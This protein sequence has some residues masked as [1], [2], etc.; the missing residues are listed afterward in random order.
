MDT[1]RKLSK[2]ERAALKVKEALKREE[3]RAK[4]TNNEALML[5]EKGMLSTASVLEKFGYDPDEEIER[6]RYDV[7]QMEYLGRGL[8]LGREDIERTKV[9]TKATQVNTLVS[10]IESARRTVE[11]LNKVD[12]NKDMHKEAL[13]YLEKIKELTKEMCDLCVQPIVEDKKS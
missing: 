12:I 5:F 11:L 4:T 10:A 2:E 1:A 7:A 9:S 6:K 13:F 3:L 8:G